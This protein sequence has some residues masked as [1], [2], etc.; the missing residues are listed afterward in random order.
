[1]RT[2]IWIVG[3]LMA[4]DVTA[5]AWAQRSSFSG[6][7]PN[8]IVYKPIDMSHAI[9][10]P[11]APRPQAAPLSN[12]FSSLSL[13]NF[14]TSKS[15]TSGLPGTMVTTPMTSPVQPLPLRR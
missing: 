15:N 9:A 13:T 7:S 12:F 10:P 3:L 8:E 1:M 11:L 14:F 6:P 4:L 5:P 2:G